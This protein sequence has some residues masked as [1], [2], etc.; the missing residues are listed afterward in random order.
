MSLAHLAGR[1]YG[2]FAVSTSRER[3]AAYVASTG[4]LPSRWTEAIPPSYAAVALFAVA[5]ALLLSEDVGAYSRIL[6]HADQRFAW[7]ARLAVGAPLAVSGRVAKV[8]ERG[9]MSFVSFVAEVLDGSGKAVVESESTFIMSGGAPP[10]GSDEQPEPEVLHRGENE[11]PGRVPLPGLG[12]SLVPLAKSASRA[13]LVTYAAAS[14]D[15][16]PL[17]WDHAS[18]RAA[19]L[20]RVVVHGLLLSAWMLQAATRHTDEE[21]PALEATFRFK[22]PVLA[23]QAAS[24]SGHVSGKERG[25]A[26]LDLSLLTHGDTSVTARMTVVE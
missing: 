25:T 19:G 7:H 6:M 12:E 15:F 11:H 5:P 18:A 4:D 8:R 23:G 20:P 21:H 16:N 22:S 26:L 1:Q 13:D 9:G 17:H 14:G 24:I 2:P 3:V 10:A